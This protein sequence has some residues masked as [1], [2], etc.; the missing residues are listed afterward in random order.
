MDWIDL[1]QDRDSLRS[2]MN[3]VMNSRVAW[4]VGISWLAEDLLAPQERLCSTELVITQSIKIEIV[5]P[6]VSATSDLLSRGVLLTVMC[7]NVWSRNLK[8]EEA[9][10]RF[11]LLH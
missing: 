3:A 4:D 6:A 9:V 8:N 5:L 2:V 7:P 1:V 11:G 10:V